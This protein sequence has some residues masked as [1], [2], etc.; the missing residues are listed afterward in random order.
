MSA[1][2]GKMT[3]I[4]AACIR[5]P[6]LASCEKFERKRSFPF[7]NSESS[8]NLSVQI[9]GKQYNKQNSRQRMVHVRCQQVSNQFQFFLH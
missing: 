2:N 6:Q 1:D 7:P 3:E 9:R 8:E 5:V 4:P